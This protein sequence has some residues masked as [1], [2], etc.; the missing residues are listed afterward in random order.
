VHYFNMKTLALASFP[1]LGQTCD[2]LLVYAHPMLMAKSTEPGRLT[3]LLDAPHSR[4]F[5]QRKDC[6]GAES[7]KG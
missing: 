5:G 7:S 6:S 1:A 4:F 2:D 3:Y